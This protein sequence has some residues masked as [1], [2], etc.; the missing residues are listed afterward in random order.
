MKKGAGKRPEITVEEIV[1]IRES[2][3]LTQTQAGKLLGGGPSAYAK[4]EAGSIKP[5]AAAANLLRLLKTYPGMLNV[6][7]V[8]EPPAV[9]VQASAPSPFEVNGKDIE[10]LPRA[11]LPALLRRLLAAEAEAHGLPADGIHV[12]DITDAPDGGEDG[13]ITWEGGPERTRFLPS[14]RCQFQL[15]SGRVQ[16]KQAGREILDKDGAVKDMIWEFLKDG[17]H[18]LMLCTYPYT[19]KAIKERKERILAALGGAGLKVARDRIRFLD[20]SQIASWTNCH[21]AVAQ[22]VKEK[23]GAGIPGPF[24]SWSHWN[25]RAEHAA[26]WVEDERLQKFRARLLEQVARPRGIARVAGPSGIGKSRLTLQALGPAEKDWSISD[27]V[28]YA[29]EA[30]ASPETINGTIQRLADSGTRAIAVVNRCVPERHRILEN[31]AL[32]ESSR[33]S[34]ITIDEKATGTAAEAVLIEVRKPAAT[35]IETIIDHTSPGLPPA[36]R[37]RLVRFA[38]E[39]P[40]TA[41]LSARAWRARGERKSGSLAQAT[42][43]GLADAIVLGRRPREP[44]LLR[45]A[46]A[47]LAAFGLVAPETK[48]EGELSEVAKLGRSLTGGDLHA[49]MEDLA[50]RDVVHQRG[51]LMLFPA[52][53]VS[54]RLT[55]RQWSEWSPAKWDKI[56]GGGIGSALS[57]R[58]ARRLS[59][60]NDTDIA[61]KVVT[62]VCRAN[63]PLDGM[64]EVSSSA[65]AAILAPLAEIGAEVVVEFLDRT[66]NEIEDWSKI[67]ETEEIGRAL[68][69]IAFRADTFADGARLLLKLA[70]KNRKNTND[71]AR[72]FISLFPVCLGNTAADGKARLEFLDERTEADRPDER[73]IIVGALAEGVRTQYFSRA[74]GDE[75]H[76][77]RPA[78]EP[79]FP[80][81]RQEALKYLSG[82]MAR[83]VP[84]AE[85]DGETGRAAR[86]ELGWSFRDLLDWDLIDAV[87]KTTARIC[88]T[89]GCWTEAVDS[90]DQFLTYDAS[91]EDQELIGRVRKLRAQLKPQE[92]EDRGRFLVTHMPSDYSGD[93]EPGSRELSHKERQQAQIQEIKELAADFA[94][95]PERLERFLPEISR[96]RQSMAFEF[97]QALAG[98]ADAPPDWL[99]P[100]TAAVA[101][102]PEEERNFSLLCGYLAGIHAKHPDAIREF[103]QQAARSAEL[104]PALPAVCRS[105]GIEPADIRLALDAL[106]AGRLSPWRLRQWEYFGEFAGIP[107]AATAPLFDWLLSKDAEAFRVGV[108]L[109]EAYADENPEN[110]AGLEVQ[111]RRMAENAIHHG[112]DT[113]TRGL[114][115]RF[116]R[117]MGKA[118][119]RGWQG[120]SARAIALALA[121]ALASIKQ[122]HQ[123]RLIKPVLPQLLSDF[124]E[125][126]W[127]VL[128]QAI[129]TSPARDGRFGEALGSRFSFKQVKHPPIL[130]LPEETLFEWCHEHPDRA[131]A[132]ATSVVPLLSDNWGDDPNQALHPLFSRLLDEFGERKDVQDEALRNIRQYSWAGSLAGHYELFLKSL[133]ALRAG[134]PKKPVRRWAKEALRWLR[135]RAKSSR[136]ADEER[137]AHWEV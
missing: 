8:T 119:E 27:L 45:K 87:E 112:A 46:A 57:L 76:G 68:S 40:G 132:F 58:A 83:I 11:G 55:A 56:L 100:I 51:D 107:A 41:V 54:M 93:P 111:V 92:L 29:D 74:V 38:A 96:G 49:A 85:Q 103:K 64:L 101:V 124:T 134:H 82:C 116:G 109:L 95:Q 44:N 115:G 69:R 5:S 32:R 37:K 137:R 21:P 84:F 15:K 63:G 9:S 14:R 31:M 99:E 23:T 71:A 90:L 16:P 77:S 126:V 105:C 17:G 7:R 123:G 94:G 48:D 42:D 98:G 10:D 30:E 19:Q 35:V 3:N 118:L 13:R 25:G 66:L 88:K 24:R 133:E 60:L 50:N 128:G 6:L 106:E 43:D 67:R 136:A 28:L 1:A 20:A 125:I 129:A 47:L 104:A 59:L 86:T 91:E 65:N 122:P 81:T 121:K 97:G 102:A 39:L 33:L 79:W 53:P 12:A 4:Y 18:Y 117:I 22:W 34:L 110:L 62:H 80:D 70:A 36:D 89:T 2:L 131:P 61:R 113:D 78:L 52:S 120:P 72:Q 135:E 73:A 75:S 114:A 130:S 108:F 26:P 127:P